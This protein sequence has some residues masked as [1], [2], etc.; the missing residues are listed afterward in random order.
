MINKINICKHGNFW[1][2]NENDVINLINVQNV[3]NFNSYL[4][5]RSNSMLYLILCST[6]IHLNVD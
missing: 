2:V 4:T 5:A 6:S 1:F 3:Y